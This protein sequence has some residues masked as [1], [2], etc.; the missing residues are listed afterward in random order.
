[1]A[2]QQM[3]LVVGSEAELA[4]ITW[5]MCYSSKRGDPIVLQKR[6]LSHDDDNHDHD[7]IIT[8]H[9]KESIATPPSSVASED[10][11]TSPT[12]ADHHYSIHSSYSWQKANRNSNQL[13]S[14][15][16]SCSTSSSDP[17]YSADL[18]MEQHQPYGP[19]VILDPHSMLLPVF[20]PHSQLLQTTQLLSRSQQI[21]LFKLFAA[22]RYRMQQELLFTTSLSASFIESTDSHTT[23]PPISLQLT[24]SFLDYRMS[25]D[26]LTVGPLAFFGSFSHSLL[27][28][29]SIGDRLG[30][31]GCI[32]LPDITVH[33]IPS[34]KHARFILASDGFWDVVSSENVRQWA[35]HYA[36][37][38]PQDLAVMLAV[39]AR[40]RRKDNEMR[41][42]DIT[43]TV[44][45]VNIQHAVFVQSEKCRINVPKRVVRCSDT[46]TFI[47]DLAQDKCPLKKVQ[48]KNKHCIVLPAGD[49]DTSNIRTSKSPS[50]HERTFKYTFDYK[51][52]NCIVM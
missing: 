33:S 15:T 31:R 24:Q 16:S 41:M 51:P 11:P 39:K 46:D 38:T 28:T 44:V 27:M 14:R 37:Q 13:W 4:A 22:N 18:S 35:F 32:A 30:P 49:R 6:V 2:E 21:Y 43:V 40:K 20:S 50:E 5:R 19:E 9:Q 48:G 34:N 3:S 10:S 36:Y 52:N 25:S 1:M 12:T 45:D 42:D 26:G 29:R 23:E 47:N 7:M 8:H 17:F